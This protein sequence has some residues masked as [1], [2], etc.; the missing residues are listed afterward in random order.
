LIKKDY[1][2][3]I[4][5]SG[6]NGLS[7][8]IVL[9]KAGLSVLILEGE[10]SIGGGMRSS[11]LTLP[12]YLHDVC[13]AIHPLA[14]DSPFFKTLPLADHGL[15]FV[16]PTVAAAHPFDDGTAAILAGSLEKTASSLGPDE[17]S[18]LRLLQPLKD[19]WAGISA[20]VMDPISFPTRPLSLPNFCY[21]SILPA[22]W[23]VR[24]YFTSSRARAFFG[25]MAAH[26]SQPL[27]NWATSAVA[28][29]LLLLGH[30]KGWPVA[31]G[32]SG[33]IATAL[34]SYFRSLG[35]KIELN[36]R[37][38]SL[39]QLPSSHT[40]LLDITPRQLLKIAGERLSSFYQWQMKRYRYGMGIFKIDWALDGPIPFTAPECRLAGTVH[41]GN[42]F[43]EISSSELGVWS[44]KQSQAPFVILA[45]QSLFDSTRVPKDKQAAWAYC[46]MPSGSVINMTESIENQVE[47]F[48]PGFKDRI[49]DRHVM[50][51][52]EMENY[53]PN[54]IGGDIGGGV[55]DIGQLF[56]RPALRFS[57]YRS[58]VK[59]IYLCSSST[60]PGGGV[61]GMCGF[62][63]ARRALKDIFRI[64]TNKL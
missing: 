14:A 1:D 31:K 4:V 50:N 56:T 44:G 19:N 15:E 13:S 9:Q 27:T 28:L 60:P 18:Y 57:P 6:P 35:G 2:A 33:Q 51:S 10:S 5:G 16:Y 17:A 55:Q 63:A 53:N 37:V 43:E 61:H 20:F 22:S 48:A 41:L 32:G 36:C 21:H 54:Y 29:T 3:V 25:G 34:G 30:G 38:N 39:E 52:I 7:A 8:G 64:Q 59:G 11:A 45:Q 23:F 49:L 12:G 26:A 58:S 42:S 47:R 24:K 40:I 62:H 46:H